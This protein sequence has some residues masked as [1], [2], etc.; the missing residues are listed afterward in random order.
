MKGYMLTK[1]CVAIAGL[2]FIPT[3]VFNEPY[4]A[5]VGAF[6]DWLPLPTGWMKSSRKINRT[7]LKLHIVVT[8][9]A[10][11]TFVAWLVTGLHVVGFSFL[12][13][14][15]VAVVFGMLMGE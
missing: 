13:V 9:V 14:W 15:W 7:F 10:Y 6:F 5:L 12:E 3:V 8:L 11:A 2:V 1:I 4:L